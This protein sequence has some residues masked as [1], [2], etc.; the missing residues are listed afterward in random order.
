MVGKNTISKL[1]R[2]LLGF[3]TTDGILFKTVV[4]TLLILIGFMYLY[5]LIFMLSTSLKSVEDLFDP[6]VS[7][8]PTSFYFGN[9]VNA[10]K[11][12]DYSNSLFRSLWIT[13]VP[14]L[15]QT[16]VASLIGY[17]FARYNFFG[18]KVIFGLVILTYVIPAQATMIPQIVLFTKM[19]WHGN[20]LSI[21]MPATLGQ[22]LN[23]AIFILIFYNFYKMI[24][25]VLDEAAQIDGA[26]QFYI[27]FKI[28]IPLSIPSFITTFLFSFV[29]YWNET[30]L[31]S[32]FMGEEGPKTL[33]LLLD[34]FV[35]A[36]NVL[37]PGQPLNEGLRMAATLLI[38][39][40]MV[41]VYI[42]LQK[43]FIEGIDNAGITGE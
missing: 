41:I 12:L 31:L 40:P 4:Y 15:L 14:A 28:A 1:K 23:A 26:S 35:V 3:K 32:L 9:Y 13:L 19:G 22:G 27:Y 6:S 16:I 34:K 10:I 39:I 2:K 8:I 30:Y 17:G 24:P 11:V 20:V 21:I 7:F 29:W 43:K 37:F 25:K 38:I 5:P 33:Q 36:Y 18:K 42:F